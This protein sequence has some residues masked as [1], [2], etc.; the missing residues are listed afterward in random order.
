VT[1]GSK[2]IREIYNN[3]SVS[4]LSKSNA[5]TLAK[6]ILALTNKKTREMLEIEI[7]LQYEQLLSQATIN[8]QFAQI[9]REF[10][11]QSS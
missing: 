10:A 3:K 7:G 9:I 6:A 11:N 1:S 4:Y 5:K 8:K 2:G